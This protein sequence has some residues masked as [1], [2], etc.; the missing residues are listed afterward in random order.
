MGGALPLRALPHHVGLP[1]DR[2]IPWDFH[3][4]RLLVP[5]ARRGVPR[6][7]VLGVAVVEN[8]SRDLWQML[9]DHG[10]DVVLNGHDHIY[11]RFVP[12]KPDGTDDLVRGMRQFT[13]GTGGANFTS[14]VTI[15]AQQ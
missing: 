12:Q 5:R 14:L 8:N 9:Y 1:A 6:Y 15:A 7:L 2:P 10:V 13:V 3:R 4:P 11:E